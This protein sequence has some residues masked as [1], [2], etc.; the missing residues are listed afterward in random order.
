MPPASYARLASQ[1]L[2]APSEPLAEALLARY[3]EKAKQIAASNPKAQFGYYDENGVPHYTGNPEYAGLSWRNQ[4]PV[5]RPEAEGSMYD[6]AYPSLPMMWS[7]NAPSVMRRNLLGMQAT[8]EWDGAR[9]LGVGHNIL[10]AQ[11]ELELAYLRA[12]AEDDLP[13]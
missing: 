1:Y 13:F 2:S 9:H 10:P 7:S 6:P 3:L 11:R 8:E 4:T 5:D 12:L